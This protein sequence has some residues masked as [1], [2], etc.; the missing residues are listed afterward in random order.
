M[1]FVMAIESEVF[2][3]CVEG[4]RVE[5]VARMIGL[6]LLCSEFFAMRH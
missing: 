1:V 3:E 4:I 2:G 5:V 6:V